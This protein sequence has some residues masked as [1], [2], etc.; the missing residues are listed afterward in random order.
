M[1][2]LYLFRHGQ[3]GTRD[4]YDN[5]SELGRQQ[6]DRLGE[7]L[8]AQR[9]EFARAYTGVLTRQRQ[10]ADATVGA[11]RGAGVPF[12]DPELVPSWNEF[13]LDDVYGELAPMLARDDESFRREFETLVAEVRASGGAE[14]AD[15][16]RKWSPC[17]IQVVEAWVH[18]R[19]PYSGESWN[20]F[21]ERV[22][23]V[24]TAMD[25]GEVN[26]AVFTSATPISVLAGLTLDIED[27]RVLR[28]AGAMYNSSITVLRLCAG[29]LRLLTFNAV[30]H[31]VD[32]AMRTHR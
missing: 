17:D 24:R 19:Y 18:Q 28:L 32:A 14:T 8:A 10:T 1:S 27:H 21:R 3:A 11:Y 31:L 13:D 5:L 4:N 16:H 26:I 20:A 22:C 30:P 25:D 7:Y 12:P 29:Q 9:V 15:V 2:F 6:A 23:S